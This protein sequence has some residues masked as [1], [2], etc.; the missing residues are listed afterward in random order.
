MLGSEEEWFFGG[1]G[2]R[3][4][5]ALCEWQS[6]CPGHGAVSKEL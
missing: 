3:E 2:M 5:A 6:K 1:K 4:K